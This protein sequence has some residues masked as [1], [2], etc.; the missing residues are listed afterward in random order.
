MVIADRLNPF[1]EKIFCEYSNLDGGVILIGAIFYTI[2]LYMDFS[3]TIDVVI[4]SAEMFGITL[5]ENFRQPFLARIY[6]IF[7]LG[8]I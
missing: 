5:P 3:G 4:G 8:G 6:R 2:Q 1:I 7:G